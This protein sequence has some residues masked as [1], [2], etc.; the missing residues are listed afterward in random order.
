MKSS[1]LKWW[2]GKNYLAKEFIK[3]FPPHI[4][5][6]E[7]FAGSC[8]CLFEKSYDD[9]A[10]IIND[11]DG[12]LMNFWRVLQDE[13]LFKAFKR[14]VEAVAFS[15]QEWIDS[16][17]KLDE[18]YGDGIH[19]CTLD[20][21]MAFFIKYRQSREGKGQSF[22]T[23]T[24]NRLRR[25]VNEQASAW[26]SSIDGLEDAYL[27]LRNVVI[28]NDD[29]VKIIK[30][31]DS[32]NTFFML[33]PPYIHN[34]R[35]TTKDYKYEM[36]DEHHIRLLLQLS[37]ICGKFMLCGYHNKI[38]DDFAQTNKW[39]VEEFQTKCKVGSSTTKPPRTEVIWMNY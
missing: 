14:R 4:T 29:A 17:K 5:Y 11:I 20:R 8:S 25:G 36:T 12:D 35:V 23:L 24:K 38:Y 13:L 18:Q 22:A 26:I 39:H 7:A 33:D 19:W 27:R 28:L 16:C 1:I 37:M 10:E 6:V 2:G 9:V 32:P 3:R 34:S 31:L 30:Q 15:Q 21:A